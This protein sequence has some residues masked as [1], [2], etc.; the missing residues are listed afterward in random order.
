MKSQELITDVGDVRVI[1]PPEPVYCLLACLSHL[2][3]R[4]YDGIGHAEL[5]AASRLFGEIV[6]LD[7]VIYICDLLNLPVQKLSDFVHFANIGLAAEQREW[8]SGDQH[9]LWPRILLVPVP[10]Q[11][12]E[13]QFH[14]VLVE[15][16]TNRDVPAF[17][18]E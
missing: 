1:S 11:G 12:N 6:N 10:G 2:A 3:A 18:Y 9:H 8:P 5:K 15:H 16:R 17:T 4:P 7:A 14:A 13:D